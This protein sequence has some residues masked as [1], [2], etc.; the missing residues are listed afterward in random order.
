MSMLKKGFKKSILVLSISALL[1]NLAGQYVY[2]AESDSLKKE[3]LSFFAHS[4]DSETVSEFSDEFF[5][6]NMEKYD[7]PGAVIT[8]VKGNKVLFSKGYGYSDVDNSIPVTTDGTLF[9]IGSVS[10]LFTAM[11]IIQLANE[12]KIDLEEDVEEYLPKLNINN[13]YDTKITMSMILTHIAGIDSEMIG[14]LSMEDPGENSVS[15]F[16]ESRTIDIVRE[17]GKIIEYSNQGMA[18]A[19][20]AVE[21]I[22]GQSCKEYI[23]NHIF[24]LIGMNQS[25]YELEDKKISKGYIKENGNVVE[26]GLEGYFKIYP[27]GGIVSTAADMAKFM[28]AE[29]KGTDS[30]V[31][32]MMHERQTGLN[33]YVPGMCYGYHEK[34][35]NDVRVVQHSGYTP[36]GFLTELSL[37][38]DE[39]VGIF[40]SINQGS[41]NS[42][43]QDY[44]DN[45][46]YTF[47]PISVEMPVSIPV[48]EGSAKSVEGTYRYGDYGRN[49]LYKGDIAFNPGVEIKVDANKNATI[50]VHEENMYTNEKTS[51]IGIEVAPLIY[52]R[53]DAKEYIT[54]KKGNNK[55]V[56]YMAKTSDSSLGTYERIKWY[57]I[58]TTQL[59]IFILLSLIG[60][61]EGVFWLIR[62]IK[63][64][65]KQLTFAEH[66]IGIVSLLNPGFY[67]ISMYTWGVRLKYG[68]PIDIIIQ[69]CIPLLAAILTI[70]LSACIPYYIKSK[71][72]SKLV[73]GNMVLVSI[74]SVIFTWLNWYWNF[75]GFNF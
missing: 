54:F 45:F 8:I 60:L 33:D 2:A 15:E 48:E 57:E 47:Y 9:R 30:S 1:F 42:V 65:A 6:K 36:D 12:G 27:I 72:V 56:Y 24:K 71:K 13:P 66:L 69:L 64:K 46:I 40:I 53:E 10:K 51:W 62:V 41:N 3:E 63:K 26:K 21:Q 4:L 67:V 35:R 37:M 34:Y 16:M 20:Y 31:V 32:K 38:L 28:I 25:K 61:I 5:K 7:V 44:I 11:A 68:V 22:S 52:Q 18:V 75:I 74:V 58:S 49:T 43:P 70:V 29:L 73:I 17:P 23:K 19:G 50:T 55:D 14:E 39:E 59:I